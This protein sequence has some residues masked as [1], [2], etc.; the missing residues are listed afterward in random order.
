[1][2]HEVSDGEVLPFD[3]LRALHTPGHSAGHLAL[4]LPR[5]GGVLFVGD[6]ASNVLRTGLGPLNEDVAESRR[7]LRSSRLSSSKSPVLRTVGRFVATQARRSVSSC[8]ASSRAARR[9]RRPAP[10]ESRRWPNV[11]SQLPEESTRE[12]SSV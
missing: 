4:L 10:T 12:P 8:G 11:A 3:G 1:M 2:A 9:V 6:A 7:S 5:E